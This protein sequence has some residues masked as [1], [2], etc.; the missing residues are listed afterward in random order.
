M[1]RERGRRLDAKRAFDLVVAA[2]VIVVTSPLLAAIAVAVRVDSRGPAMFRQQRV[3]LNGEIFLIHKFRSMRVDQVGPLVSVAGDERVTRVGRPLRRSKL[4]ELPQVLDVLLGH[5]SLVG[6]R[7]EVPKYV[8]AWS[9]AARQVIL[10]VRPGITDPAS[11]ALRDEDALLASASDPERF[12]LDVLVPRKTAI[13]VRYVQSQSLVGDIRILLRTVGAV[14][15][16][17]RGRATV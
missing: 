11:I 10:S 14:L 16:V 1:T 9:A 5:M 4:D 3:G 17:G 15:R 12:Y 7:P 8:D 6:P 13:Y 2:L